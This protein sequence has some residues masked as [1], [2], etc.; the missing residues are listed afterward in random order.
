MLSSG[1]GYGVD[2]LQAFGSVTILAPARAYPGTGDAHQLVQLGQSRAGRLSEPIGTA[3]G[4]DRYEPRSWDRFTGAQV[5]GFKGCSCHRS[6]LPTVK[7]G[8]RRMAETDSLG[9]SL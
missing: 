7:G 6:S 2:A 9:D 5:V 3:V 1:T 8:T 4:A